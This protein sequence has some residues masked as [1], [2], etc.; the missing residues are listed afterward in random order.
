MTIGHFQST[1]TITNLLEL[2]IAAMTNTG[3]DQEKVENTGVIGYEW[4]W[5]VHGL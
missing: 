2:G 1:I 3:S 4:M 5:P